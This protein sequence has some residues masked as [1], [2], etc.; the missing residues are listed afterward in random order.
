[1]ALCYGIGR[2]TSPPTGQGET[3]HGDSGETIEEGRP[4]GETRG[5]ESYSSKESHT[6]QEEDW[7]GVIDS[8]GVFDGPRRRWR[9]L[10]V[11]AWRRKNG[12]LRL[13]RPLV[14]GVRLRE[15]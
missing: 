14:E 2:S 11:E 15:E 10:F 3:T 8:C 7:Q 5:E 1:M 9:G 12:V 6:R 4:E 13:R